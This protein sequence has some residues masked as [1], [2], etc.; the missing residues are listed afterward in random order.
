MVMVDG[1]G[2]QEHRWMR[3]GGAVGSSCKWAESV[4][5]DDVAGVGDGGREVVE[6]GTDRF[7]VLGWVGDGVGDGFEE[8][9]LAVCWG[10]LKKRWPHC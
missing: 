7:N 9:V 10:Y 8:T 4:A 5:V 3:D 6:M 1:G 2:G